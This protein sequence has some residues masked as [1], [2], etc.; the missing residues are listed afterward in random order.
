MV[1]RS[2][3]LIQYQT[4]PSRRTVVGCFT[5]TYLPLT[6]CQLWISKQDM[7]PYKQGV[8]GMNDMNLVRRK[9][10]G[11][12]KIYTAKMFRPKTQTVSHSEK[13]SAEETRCIK[14]WVSVASWSKSTKKKGSEISIST[15]V[16]KIS[17]RSENIV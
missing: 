11:V 7:H 2:S 9:C 8:A 12:L 13:S 1:F 6:T 5:V 3:F 4:S 16:K 14:E 15:L 10:V 17:C